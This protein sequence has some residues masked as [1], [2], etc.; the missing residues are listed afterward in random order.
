MLQ[1][2]PGAGKT[3]IV[4]LALLE[5]P[6]LAGR[7]I[8]VLE[9]RRLA[10]RAA[11][12]RM[13]DLLGGT[14]GAT[15]GYR[16]RRESAVGPATRIEVVTEGILTR[17]LQDDPA[18]ES[19]GLVIFDEFHERSVHADLGL[20]L[21]LE[22]RAI[23]RRDLRILVMS[24]TLDGE[25]I[26]ALLGGAPIVT[27]AGQSFPVET[28]YLA[29]RP[30]TRM[31]SAAASA[32]RQALIE[33]EGD[34]LVFLPGQ[35]EIRRTADLLGPGTD[36][37]AV[38]PLYGNL[39]QA[40][41][42]AAL[43]PDPSGRRKVLLSTAIAETS[44]TIEGVRVV[45]DS[46]FARV[47]KFSPGSGMTRLATVRVSRAS[48]DQR[49]G[50]AGRTAPGV[51]YRLWAAT[52]DHQLLQRTTPE[53]LETALTPLALELA[54]RGVGDATALAWLDP[55]P[56]G[57]LAEARALLRQLGAIDA[58]DRVTSHGRRMAVLGTDP[59]LARL[60]IMGAE[61]GEAEA[62]A[63]LTALLEERDPLRGTGGPPDA[64]IQLRL[65]LIAERDRPS[66]YHGYDVDRGVLHR[67][68][69]SARQW[70]R[71]LGASQRDRGSR[72]SFR[73]ERT[74]F[75]LAL[76][77]PDRIGQRRVGQAGRFLLRNGQ[78]ASV[79]SP[80]LARADFI[81][82][83]ELDGDRRESR[84]WLGATLSR[85]EIDL[86]FGEQVERDEVIEWDDQA[87]TVVA[88][89]R[90]RL[91]ALILNEKPLRDPD[92][93]RVRATLVAWL[94]GAGLGVLPWSEASTG[95]RERL[96]F[97]NLVLGAPWPAVSDEALLATLEDWLGPRFSD[98]RRRSDL[99]RLDLADALLARLD[100]EQR[101]ALDDLAPTHLAVPSGSRI[102]VDYSVP[103]TPVLA[104]RLQE[105]FGLEETPRVAGGR[106]PVTL[107]LLSP[108]R[109]PVQVT[110]D[111]A[112]FWRTSYFDV[113]KEMKGRYPRH[114]WPEDPVKAVPTR[115]PKRR[116][117]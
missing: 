115:N 55:P 88:V 46:G 44:L 23:L 43:R 13:A 117:G 102:R 10:A 20:A 82:A 47:P 45:V 104:V 38:Y 5:A 113:R 12:R 28:R 18:L 53:I 74:G 27:S 78:G 84:V 95:L 107:H 60:L 22:S 90:E 105:V 100:W 110:R 106:I 116:K 111:L 29:R 67:I 63:R 65:D 25:P 72:E 4:P 96:G 77:Y 71:S 31:E 103:A 93:S 30:E 26:A 36:S 24:A 70:H 91:G 7:K 54:V 35:G 51:C 92:P 81:V 89:Q 17:M 21:A 48:A 87:E 61:L 66:L 64:D 15:V 101:R 97:L 75:L 76:A 114:E 69:E 19:A 41:Q 73:V 56:A 99:A 16:I 52:E 68:R 62:A 59:R 98:L 9:P 94:K 1:A 34:I 11:A 86:H 14:L 6:W 112:G 57:A 42:D 108:A 8:L 85:E 109:R 37:W 3:T 83:A 49:R 40:E 79:D 32:V 2:P 58:A 33:D 50:R 80:T 39:S